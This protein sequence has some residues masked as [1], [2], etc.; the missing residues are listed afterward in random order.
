MQL[1]VLRAR[2]SAL[3][4]R[5]SNSRLLTD[6]LASS[7]TTR[8][9]VDQHGDLSRAQA[10]RCLF[11]CTVCGGDVL[12]LTDNGRRRP[13]NQQA[14]A[15][16][17]A[18]RSHTRGGCD[19]SHCCVRAV[20]TRGLRTPSSLAHVCGALHS[21]DGACVCMAKIL[22]PIQK[23]PAREGYNLR[24][25]TVYARTHAVIRLTSNRD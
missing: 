8:P 22:A 9:S 3:L 4:V 16:S 20:H 6:R 7:N 25:P 14:S 13:Y 19:C 24:C 18:D 11:L 23:L 5:K 17:R 2:V 10:T 1:H 12:V 21:T 15:Y